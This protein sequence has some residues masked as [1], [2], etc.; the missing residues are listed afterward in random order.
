MKNERIILEE[1][2]RLEREGR[3]LVRVQNPEMAHGLEYAQAQSAARKLVAKGLIIRRGVG[4][5]RLSAAG[6]RAMDV[7]G[8]TTDPARTAARSGPRKGD[9]QLLPYQMAWKFIRMRRQF[10][11]AEL[12]TCLD[13]PER[14]VDPRNLRGYV[15][16]LLSAGYLRVT[17]RTAR[18][19]KT[20]DAQAKSYA[21]V[22]DTG[23]LAPAVRRVRGIVHDPNLKRDVPMDGIGLS[24]DYARV[25]T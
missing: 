11:N 10:T 16:G 5:Y 2:A 13:D 17:H 20:R 8:A 6:W 22:H 18:R 24:A 9:G 3:H 1:V 15:A 21:L 12:M 23:V 4:R 7:A 14:P 19:T 25:M